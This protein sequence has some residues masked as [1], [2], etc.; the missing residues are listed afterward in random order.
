MSTG[1]LCMK[2]LIYLC[3]CVMLYSVCK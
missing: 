1:V 2:E 3:F